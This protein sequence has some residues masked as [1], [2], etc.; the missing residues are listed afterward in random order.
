MKLDTNKPRKD[1]KKCVPKERFKFYPEAQELMIV[2]IHN[3]CVLF[4]EI[5]WPPVFVAD[6]FK[7]GV[8]LKFAFWSAGGASIHQK[9]HT[10]VPWSGISG[11][12][13]QQADRDLV[14]AGGLVDA[15]AE[16]VWEIMFKCCPKCL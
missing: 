11:G 10:T 12:C 6:E 2:F 13:L 8:A 4:P 9:C 15:E 1:F 7:F 3:P 5:T 14:F 16:V